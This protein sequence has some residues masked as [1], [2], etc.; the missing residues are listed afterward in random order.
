MD[1]QKSIF[2]V[3]RH[4]GVKQSWLEQKAG[5]SKGSLTHYLKGRQTP[6]LPALEKIADASG[7]KLSEFIALGED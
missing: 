2:A 7:M 1:I 4:R 6:S 5:I 3:T